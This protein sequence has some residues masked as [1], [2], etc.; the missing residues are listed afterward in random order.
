MVGDEPVR[1]DLRMGGG[2]AGSQV[3][4]VVLHAKRD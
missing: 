4:P 2:G 1:E 3:T